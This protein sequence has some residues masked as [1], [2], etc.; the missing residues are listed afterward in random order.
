MTNL[1]SSEPSRGG[2]KARAFKWTTAEDG[3]CALRYLAEAS[4]DVVLSDVRMPGLSGIDS[5][6]RSGS[7]TSKCPFYS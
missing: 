7:V 5:S 3:A 6:G 1:A 2:L 4:F